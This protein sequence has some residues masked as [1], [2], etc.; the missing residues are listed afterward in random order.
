MRKDETIDNT[1][2]K[3]RAHKKPFTLNPGTTA[4]ASKTNAA[5]ITKVKSQKVKILIGNVKI[6]SIG[7]TK[8]FRTPSTTATIIAVTKL[9]TFTP[10]KIYEVAKTA[11]LFIRR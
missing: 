11:K 10:G 9:S 7:L 6:I 3:A 5:F 1:R 2:E 4:D 8:V